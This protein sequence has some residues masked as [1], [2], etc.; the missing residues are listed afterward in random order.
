MKQQLFAVIFALAYA[1][2]ARP[3]AAAAETCDRATLV[4]VS[5]SYVAAQAA[6]QLE[7]LKGV[8][9]DTVY[10]QNFKTATLASGLLSQ[11]FKIDHNRSTHDTTQCA[12]YTELIIADSKNPHVVA[13]QIRLAPN[14]T[15]ISKIETIVTSTGDWLFNAA[16]TLR[17]ASQESWGEIPEGQ[18]D[19][20]AVIQAAADA[21]LDLFSNKSVKVPWGSPCARLE[22]GSYIQPSCNVGVPSGIKQTNRRY[23]VDEVTGAVDVFFDFAGAEPDSH[24]FRVESGKLRYVHTLTVMH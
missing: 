10:T 22:G 11:S 6:G 14:S 23:V 19:T 2:T 24:E 8:N 13:T 5:D 20:R 1:A 7:T 18:R 15:N 9:S 16:A 4:A 17:Y 21:Y 3:T 12:T